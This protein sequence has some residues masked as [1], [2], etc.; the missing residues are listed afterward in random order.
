M[1]DKELDL[2][3]DKC[4]EF[5][6]HLCMGQILGVKIAVMG[7]ELSAPESNKDLIVFVENDRCIADAIMIVSNTRLGRRS[8]KFR[9]YGKMAGT[10]VNT[11][12]NRAFRVFVTLNRKNNEDDHENERSVLY[13][14]DSEV[15]GWKE[16]SVK[17]KP[18]E[19]PGKPQRIVSCIK[20][21]EKIFDG[22]DTLTDNGPVCGPC[23][24]GCYYNVL[25]NQTTSGEVTL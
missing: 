7:L 17:F 3:L 1:T 23:L 2:L 9:D 10:F 4:V 8:L 22:K 12:T 19:L 14:P 21:G 16:V 5:H 6:G 25:E 18:F 15:V 13:L 11:K 20:C 24:S